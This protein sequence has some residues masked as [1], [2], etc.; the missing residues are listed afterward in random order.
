MKS[1]IV[2]I[3][4][5]FPL[6]ML[7][8]SI[9]IA[10]SK[11]NNFFHRLCIAMLFFAVGLSGIWGFIMHAFYPEFTSA[12]I[13]W[14]STPFEYEVAITN[15]AMGIMGIFAPFSST[16]FK[17][18]TAVLVAIFLIGAAVGHIHQIISVHNMHSGNVGTILWTDFL[19]PIV[20][21]I[22]IIF[23]REKPQ[24]QINWSNH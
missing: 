1:I 18:A 5:N 13:G 20:L 8:L 21:W 12:E 9:L 23:G 15:L 16:G 19:I 3:L 22:A 6:V 7:A 14:Q 11:S 2:F 17:K 10:F 4:S 24:K